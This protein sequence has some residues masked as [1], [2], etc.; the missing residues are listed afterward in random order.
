LVGP[1]QAAPGT[2][3]CRVDQ[4]WRRGAARRVGWPSSISPRNLRAT[5]ACPRDDG[6]DPPARPA[7][8][9]EAPSDLATPPP[10][11]A[12]L[13]PR[14]VLDLLDSQREHRPLR[15][16]ATPGV[17]TSALNVT[18]PG[19]AAPSA[20]PTSGSSGR[21]LSRDARDPSLAA[22]RDR[23]QPSRSARVRARSLASAGQDRTGVRSRHP[24][25]LSAVEYAAIIR[26]DYR[27][28][29]GISTAL[30]SAC[31]WRGREEPITRR[32]MEAP[33]RSSPELIAL[34]SAG[35]RG[36]APGTLNAWSLDPRCLLARSRPR[37]DRLALLR[38]RP[39]LPEAGSRHI[40]V[41]R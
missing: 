6:A 22:R 27:R 26:A 32:V 7:V 36:R 23:P 4:P 14:T 1:S 34:P 33:H 5:E 21:V 8:R 19:C 16:A 29:R 41:T 20:Q 15:A 38:A 39:A 28:D 31:R 37:S 3:Y 18:R 11:A 9:S 10:T 25:P 35:G 2:V 12:G 30:R 24:S 40:C 17:C 13:P